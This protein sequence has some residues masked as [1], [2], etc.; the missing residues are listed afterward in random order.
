MVDKP[1]TR[2]ELISML[3]RHEGVEPFGYQCSEGKLTVGVGRNIDPEGGLGLSPDEIDYLLE[4]DIDRTIADLSR[5]EFFQDLTESQKAGLI[6]FHFNVGGTTFRKFK[7]MIAALDDGD[8]VEAAKE[9][10]DSRYAKQVGKRSKTIAAL[11]S[12]ED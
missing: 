10:L 2:S 3:R 12:G 6:D 1:M 4:N 11:I 5:F 8:Y 9:L 7:N